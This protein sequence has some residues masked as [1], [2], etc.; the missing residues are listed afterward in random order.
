MISRIWHGWTTRSNAAAYEALLLTA[1]LPGIASRKIA[2]YLGVRLDRRESDDEVEFVT[3]MFFGSQDAVREFAGP[4][5]SE[6][7]VPD[8]ARALLSR[9]DAHAAHYHVVAG[10]R[11]RPDL[12]PTDPYSAIQPHVED[13]K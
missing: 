8:S 4:T 6:S 12:N 11:V 3:T 13:T 1:I 10:P 7:V 5:S 2:G 9:F